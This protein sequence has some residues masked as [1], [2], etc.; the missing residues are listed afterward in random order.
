MLFNS[1]RTKNTFQ[2]YVV[3]SHSQPIANHRIT[4]ANVIEVLHESN[5]QELFNMADT[6]DSIS[7]W[8]ITTVLIVLQVVIAAI[9]LG[10]RSVDFI[11]DSER[12]R[13]N[14]FQ[15]AE[16]SAVKCRVP[17]Y[18]QKTN[19]YCAQLQGCVHSSILCVGLRYCTTGL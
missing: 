17:E 1:G 14:R 4:R 11:N 2:I 13:S 7:G 9:P 12:E 18:L 6:T 15:Q 8:S 19:I 16:L 10:C 3:D 5:S